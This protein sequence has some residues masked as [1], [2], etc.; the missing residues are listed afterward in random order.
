MDAIALQEDELTTLESIYPGLIE[1]NRRDTGYVLDI[2]VPITLAHPTPTR[3]TT[4]R[5]PHSSPPPSADLL[6]TR[7][8]PLL[9]RLELPSAYPTSEPP[10]V[11]SLRAP[12]PAASGAWLSR[13]V[14]TC[15]QE[16]LG[17]FWA[18]EAVGGE[19]VGVLWSWWEWLAS[20]E[21]LIEVGLLADQ[22]LV[23]STPPRL[24]PSTF[25]LLLKKHDAAVA[26][27]D[28]EETAF[29]C[30]ICFEN[31]KGKK[32]VQLPKC[33]CIFCYSCL[34]SFW[35]LAI[36]EGTLENVAC[37]SIDCVKA[38]ASE[39]VDH[40]AGAFAE[41]RADGIGSEVVASVVGQEMADRW[42]MLSEK[43]LVD[44]NPE[45]TFC[46]REACQAAVPPST[47]TPATPKATPKI[48]SKVIRLDIRRPE[49]ES[50]PEKTK[51]RQDT[52]PDEAS[53]LWDNCRR[54]PKCHYTFCLVCRAVWH[55]VHSPC[56]FSD[57]EGVIKEYQDGDE[58]SRARMEKRLG[59]KGTEALHALIREHDREAKFRQWVRDNAATCPTCSAS[60]QKIEGCNHMTC[61]LCST[62]F[63]YRCHSA[64]SPSDPYQ[65][66]REGSENP[67]CVDRLFDYVFPD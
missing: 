35:N 65:H 53:N 19:C 15:A 11:V 7:L 31:R 50:K 5:T 47:T 39:K 20:G 49:A 48:P 6:L 40:A 37:P 62:H 32:S 57:I 33:G 27:A 25:H 56:Q 42:Q 44:S 23:L 43:R 60:I 64:I 2:C 63:C 4:P 52:D 46:P 54:C 45:Y 21:F 34:S 10:R 16:R 29:S 51:I 66:F 8:P 58:E 26:R 30:A 18:D 67:N 61:T 13:R 24:P 12:L 17:K 1:T 41:Q 38:R 28:F 9:A 59:V 55:G 36:T 14:L 22:A 3:L